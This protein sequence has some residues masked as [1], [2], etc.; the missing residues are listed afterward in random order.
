MTENHKKTFATSLPGKADEERCAFFIGVSR[1]KRRLIMTVSER[2]ETLPSKPY[3]WIVPRVPH[4]EFLSYA[5]PFLSNA[6]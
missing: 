5:R 6:A 4:A 2:R 3:K 1:A